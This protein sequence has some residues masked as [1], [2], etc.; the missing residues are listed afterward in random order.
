MY[1]SV[2]KRHFPTSH[3]YRIDND[4]YVRVSNTLLY[5]PLLLFVPR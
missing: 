1:E 5:H 3:H 4:Y 2:Q